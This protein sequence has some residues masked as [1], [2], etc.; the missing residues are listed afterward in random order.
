MS[1]FW[2]KGKKIGVEIGD[3]LNEMNNCIKLFHD[4]F[5]EFLRGA[6]DEK[7]KVMS[8]V[9]GDS[10]ARCDD[11][12]HDIERKLFGGALMPGARSDIFGLLESVDKVANKAEAVCDFIYL[13]N[14]QVPDELKKDY[15]ELMSLTLQCTDS[16]GEA[17]RSIFKNIKDAERLVVV[18]DD[19]ESKV[20]DVER[21]L[22]KKIFNMNLELAHKMMLRDLVVE[23]TAISDRAEN[24]SNLLEVMA[25]KRRA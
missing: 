17:L 20:D 2:G 9:V 25:V 1:M 24:A 6:E 4:F 8:Q 11:L 5:V 3:Y 13:Q 22:V 7:L 19:W 15:E 23:I 10:E 16:L 18:V 21:T 12:R 14:V